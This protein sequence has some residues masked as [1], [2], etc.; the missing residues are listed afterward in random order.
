VKQFRELEL[1]GASR[2]RSLPP[3]T[4]PPVQA[5]FDG[6]LA[7]A[8]LRAYPAE[9]NKRRN[10]GEEVWWYVCNG[11]SAPWANFFLDQSGATHRVLFWQTFGRHSDGLLYWGVN[12]WPGFEARTMKTPPD[13]KKWPKVPWNDG[14]RNGD[15]YFLYPGPRGPLTSLR[16]EIMRDGVEDYDALR[17]LEDLVKRKGDRMPASV[18]ERARQAL[19]LSPEVFESMAKYPTDAST[20]VER[21]RLVNELIVLFLNAQKDK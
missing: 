8:H 19:T 6:A 18:R 13:D 21:R 17:M 14:G 4:V 1:P 3:W 16:F 5:G 7:V 11:P 15:G 9:A 20:M 10:Q 2:L 12:Y